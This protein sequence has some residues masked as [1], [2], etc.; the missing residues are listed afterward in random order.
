M[1]IG[2]REEDVHEAPA[3]IANA[4]S[5]PAPRLIGA[6]PARWRPHASR[7]G[8]SRSPRPT[9]ATEQQPGA[10]VDRQRRARTPARV[11]ARRARRSPRR[12]GRAEPF[13]PGIREPAEQRLLGHRRQEREREGGRAPCERDRRARDVRRHD[14]GAEPAQERETRRQVWALAFEWDRDRGQPDRHVRGGEQRAARS[15]G[16]LREGASDQHRNSD[17]HDERRRPRLPSLA[18]GAYAFDASA[19]GFTSNATT[20]TTRGSNGA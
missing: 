10:H 18:S 14:D 15:G 13:E 4:R 2:S 16:D 17:D 19:Q 8:P 7:R 9:A 11:P 12:N 1:R 6:P 5:T 3:S 20:D